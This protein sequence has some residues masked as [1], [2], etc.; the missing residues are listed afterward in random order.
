MAVPDD[1]RATIRAYHERTCHQPSAWARALGYLDW[2]SQPNP[3]RRYQ[4]APLVALELVPAG[5]LPGYELA[6]REGGLLPVPVD[7]RSVSQLFMDSL[8]LSAWKEAEGNRWS[9]RVNP[10]SGNLHP[11]EGYLVSGAVPGLSDAPAVYHYAPHEHALERLVDL[12]EWGRL[13]GDLPRGAMLVGLTSI[14]WRESWKYGERALRYCQHDLGHA[15]AA[16]AVAAAGLGWATRLLDGPS[17]ASIAALLGVARQSGPEAEVPECLLA[18]YPAGGVFPAEQQRHVR[19]PRPSGPWAGV[20]A[21][22]S[23]EHVD[24]PVIGAA[25]AATRRDVP[26]PAEW[27]WSE[28]AENTSLRFDVSPPMLRRIVHGRRSAVDLDGRTGMTREDFYQILLKCVPGEGQV[29]FSTLPW[30]PCVHLGLFVHR[31]GDLEPGLYLLVRDAE[32]VTALRAWT[33]PGF[34]WAR[35]DG[36]PASLQL[37]RLSEGDCRGLASRV[38]CGQAIAGDGAFAVAMLAEYAQPIA[39]WGA[40]HWRRLHWEAG[41]IGQVLYLEA[42]ATGVRGTGIGCFFDA[43]A[44]AVFGSPDDRFRSIYHFTVGGPVDDLRLRTLEP[45]GHLTTGATTSLPAPSGVM[46]PG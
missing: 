10:S 11:T 14:P 13:A 42:E 31:V 4:G 25:E 36:C 28:R 12:P 34:L 29:P 33:K 3:F 17:S 27:W 7:R 20:P 45:Y 6:F 43:D 8:A 5:D 30:R 40:W 19:L 24:W 15:V 16:V 18:V 35:P 32:A 41:A 39:R 26:P 22:L 44:G 21:V 2:D 37:F 46:A 1:P 38:S 9:L 23:P